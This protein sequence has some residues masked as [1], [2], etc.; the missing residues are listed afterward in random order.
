MEN[1]I[2]SSVFVGLEGHGI[3]TFSIGLRFESSAQS[4]GGYDLRYKDTAAR[5]VEGMCRVTK[6][7]NIYDTIGK[8]V[9]VDS[10]HHKIHRIGHP[11]RDVWFGT[12]D[13]P[14]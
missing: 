3:P 10:T 7:S 2:I 8:V 6:C 9:R 12:A 11:L 4:F 5:F 13:M 1:A 14:T